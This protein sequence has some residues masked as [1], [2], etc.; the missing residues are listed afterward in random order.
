MTLHPILFLFWGVG[1]YLVLLR[2]YSRW[3]VGVHRY[4]RDQ[5]QFICVHGKRP[6]HYTVL[7]TP[8]LAVSY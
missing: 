4:S 1:V 3:H 7:L 8:R 5:I 2:V 6:P